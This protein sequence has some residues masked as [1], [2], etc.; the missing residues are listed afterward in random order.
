LCSQTPNRKSPR[1]DAYTVEQPEKE[2]EVIPT[3]TSMVVADVQGGAMASLE[4]LD[5]KMDSPR[6]GKC[7]SHLVVLTA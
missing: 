7:P 6:R 5:V 4:R 3:V 1:G 2:Q